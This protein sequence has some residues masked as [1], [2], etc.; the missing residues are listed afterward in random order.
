MQNEPEFSN[1]DENSIKNHKKFTSTELEVPKKPAARLQRYFRSKLNLEVL[2]FDDKSFSIFMPYCKNKVLQTK[3]TLWYHL[4]G[5][6]GYVG[7]LCGHVS[8]RV[9]SSFKTK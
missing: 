5:L 3:H 7:N 1:G 2:F 9:G 6:L 8:S 4:T